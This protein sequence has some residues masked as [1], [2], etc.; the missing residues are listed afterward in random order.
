M[1]CPSRRNSLPNGT[2]SC[3]STAWKGE[4]NFSNS[5][6]E[7]TTNAHSS[8]RYSVITPGAMS[9][10]GFAARAPGLSSWRDG[11]V[12]APSTADRLEALA[13]GLEHALERVEQALRL[14]AVVRG[15]VAHV[16]VDGDEARLGPRMD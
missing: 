10:G 4:R 16:H 9:P 3:T 7:R 6:A 13:G 12:I 15:V 8:V 5:R 14:V 2:V 1:K 11:S